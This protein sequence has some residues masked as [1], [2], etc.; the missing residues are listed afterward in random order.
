MEIPA[1]HRA[2]T[3]ADAGTAAQR[4][5]TFVACLLLM[6]GL[7]AALRNGVHAWDAERGRNLF[8][9]PSHF[10]TGV[11]WFAI[12]VAGVWCARTA[13]SARSFLE[14]TAPLL[15]GWGVAGWVRDGDPSDVFARDPWLNGGHVALGLTGLVV[16]LL[17]GRRARREAAAPGG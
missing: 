2:P 1:E 12:G 14:V 3:A 11:A 7:L 15:V 5:A 10:L 9:F 13:S 16:A 6:L 4:W 8:V 17:D